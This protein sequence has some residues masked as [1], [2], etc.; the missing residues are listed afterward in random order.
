[1]DYNA[2]V[3]LMGFV[4]M[5]LLFF[6]GAPIFVSMLVSSFVGLWAIGGWTMVQTQFTSAPLSLAASYTYAVL[7]L[8]ML[9]GVMAGE[10]GIAEGA[11]LS[12]KNWMGRRRGGLL[13]A[14]IVANTVF[15]ACSA[16]PTAGNIV[17][18]KIALPELDKAGYDK[19]NALAC[20]TGAGC[21]ASLIP[22]SIAIVNFSVLN[23]LSIS[24]A[25]SAG[26]CAGVITT[27]VMIIM[28]KIVSIAKPS[29]V[30]APSAE[31]VPWKVK[32][33]G[34]KLL[35]PIVA[36]FAI[37]MGGTFTGAFTATVGG[38]VAAAVITIYALAK[39]MPIKKGLTVIRN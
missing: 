31:R 33:S 6:M 9:V 8:F 38:A 36:L 22:P 37:I 10:T 27:I 26:V 20:I 5:L 17:F 32:L 34:L 15:G 7:P 2:L 12:L 23:D 18:T 3:G 35:V 25:L 11:Y 19:S 28:V 13:N 16:V 39:K 1:M 24:R 14:T 30:P 4:F 21:L 29:T